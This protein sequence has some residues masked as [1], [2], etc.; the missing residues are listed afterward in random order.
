MRSLII[1]WAWAQ[2]DARLALI[3]DW[4]SRDLSTAARAA[5]PASSD[6]S[7]RRYFRVFSAR[8]TYIVMD[9]PP[10]KEDVR[11]YLKVSALLA[12]L[13]AHVP[14]VHESD[15][16]RGLCCSRISARS[17]ICSGSRRSGRS[18]ALYADALRVLADI[19]VRGRSGAA[20]L[21]P[22]TARRSRA[23]LP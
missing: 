10:G 17:P 11:P 15:L 5:L 19:Q 6:A 16:A 9:A 2:T 12:A 14:Q 3:R 21:P 18:R 4:L 7:F 13:G 8:G 22:T 23:S 20:S 1:I